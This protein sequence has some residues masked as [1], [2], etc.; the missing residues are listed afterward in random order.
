MSAID[1]DGMTLS[2]G[3]KTY[4]TAFEPPM[5][6][7]RDARERV[8]VLDKECLAVLNKSDIT[9]KD[10]LP[11]LGLYSLEFAII[12]ATFISYSQRWW[13]AKGQ[14]VETLL[15]PG[16]AKFSW[17]IQPW[18]ITGLCALHFAEAVHFA[19]TRLRKHSVNIRTPKWWLWF[20]SA[21]IEGFFCF[22]R[23]DLLVER[24]HEEKAKQK[25]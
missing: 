24:K 1:L 17:T 15:G 9:V 5:S 3:G 11:P 10:Y 2:C 22:R 25:H 16:F 8:V 21:F 18:L 12:S 20:F 23:F 4:R 14:I 13:F 6:S 7:Y 19:N